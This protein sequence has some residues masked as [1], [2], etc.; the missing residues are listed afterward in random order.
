ML[1]YYMAPT[2]GSTVSSHVEAFLPI[3]GTALVEQV[4]ERTLTDLF[5]SVHNT[6]IEFIVENG[7]G[8]IILCGWF[9]LL[10]LRGF[11]RL[12][13]SQ[14]PLAGGAKAALAAI[15]FMLLAASLNV[16]T[17][18]TVKIY[19]FY[20]TLLYVVQFL[21]SQTADGSAEASVAPTVPGLGL[22]RDPRF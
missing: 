18:S 21:S 12:A 9:G 2:K 6:Y 4:Y 10:V 22:P 13:S 7:L 8:G 5:T 14:P 16:M 19:W 3:Q 17:D 20:A 11:K 15:L 1:P